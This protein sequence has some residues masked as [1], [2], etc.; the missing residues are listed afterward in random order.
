MDIANEKENQ[1]ILI[2]FQGKKKKMQFTQKSASAF[3]ST[4]Q[5]YKW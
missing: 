1:M 5:F 2:Y 4:R 3:L